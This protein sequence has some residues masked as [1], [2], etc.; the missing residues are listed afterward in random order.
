MCGER[1][2]VLASYERKGVLSRWR[3]PL[4]ACP[5]AHSTCSPIFQIPN[6]CCQAG[7]AS[8]HHSRHFSHASAQFCPERNALQ[9]S[10]SLCNSLA[11]QE[12]SSRFAHVSRLYLF[13][14]LLS[15]STTKGDSH[16][17]SGNTST[18]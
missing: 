11:E 13:A 5:V 12:T 10:C 18:R 6:E 8:F 4:Q 2:R 9:R 3:G 1:Y 15:T 14:L 7:Y 16:S 17:Q